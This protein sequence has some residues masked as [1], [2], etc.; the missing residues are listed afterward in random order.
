LAC[1]DEPNPIS[2]SPVPVPAPGT[3]G[4]LEYDWTINGRQVGSDCEALGAVLF[5]AIIADQGY[6]VGRL[7]VPCEDFHAS[8]G[9]YADDFVSRSALT[10]V[11]GNLA[12]GRIVEDRFLIAD[13][14]VT[15]LVVDFTNA[16]VPMQPVPDAGVAPSP[17]AEVPEVPE[18][19]PPAT[20]PD[21][22]TDAGLP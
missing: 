13:G 10:D 12:V 17:D 20:E 22:G 1:S 9:L 7:S 16:A 4:T 21:A 2:Y 11:S 18:V 19:P 5:E 15:T 6:R 8:V 14:L 3:A